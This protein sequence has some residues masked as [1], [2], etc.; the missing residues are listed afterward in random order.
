[1]KQFRIFNN[2]LV[3]ADLSNDRLVQVEELRGATYRVMRSYLRN[4]WRV[5]AANFLLN[6]CELPATLV[7]TIYYMMNYGS[8]LIIAGIVASLMFKFYQYGM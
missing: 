7:F 5:K 4:G 8:L 3:L 2:K 6:D 1:M